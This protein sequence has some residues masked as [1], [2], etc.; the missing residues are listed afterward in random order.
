MALGHPGTLREP[1]C[2]LSL[3]DGDPRVPSPN[4]SQLPLDPD[5]GWGDGESGTEA[6]GHHR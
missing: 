3:V 1:K 6:S 5:Q 4:P 2:F